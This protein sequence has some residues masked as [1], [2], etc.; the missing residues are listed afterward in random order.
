MLKDQKDNSSVNTEKLK[1]IL[2]NNL[3]ASAKRLKEILQDN[4]LAKC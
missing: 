4:S 3:L 2:Q 1:E